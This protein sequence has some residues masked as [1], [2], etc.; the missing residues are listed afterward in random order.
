MISNFDRT[1]RFRA[2]MRFLEENNLANNTRNHLIFDKLWDNGQLRD[3]SK[4][5][6]LIDELREKY[7][8]NA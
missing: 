6:P 7:G 2:V 1:R 4:T 3:E 5:K 8:D